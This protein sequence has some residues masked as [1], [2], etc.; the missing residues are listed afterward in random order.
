MTTSVISFLSQ[1]QPLPLS[2]ASYAP[3]MLDLFQFPL[4]YQWLSYKHF[5]LPVTIPWTGLLPDP[6]SNQLMPLTLRT[7][8][9]S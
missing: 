1:V 9:R 2:I 7:V 3:A 8:P 6:L 5:S 4:E